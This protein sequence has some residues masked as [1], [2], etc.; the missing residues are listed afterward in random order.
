MRNQQH[1]AIDSV[2]RGDANDTEVVVNAPQLADPP[3]AIYHVGEPE[4]LPLVPQE[5]TPH[6]RSANEPAPIIDV[7]RFPFAEN[8][9]P[10]TDGPD[11][12]V[13]LASVPREMAGGDTGRIHCKA[14]HR[15]IGW[16]RLE[17]LKPPVAPSSPG[18]R[19]VT[20]YP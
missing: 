16:W 14:A 20:A 4:H 5:H 3:E 12:E 8:L 1:C 7:V 19:A 15:V 10:L 18:G 17:Q 2:A 13:R 6:A 11:K 9:R